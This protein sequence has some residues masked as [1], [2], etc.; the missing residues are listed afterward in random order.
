T[1]TITTNTNNNINIYKIEYK[2]NDR[3]IMMFECLVKKI[4]ISVDGSTYIST[5]NKWN[6]LLLSIVLYYREYLCN[7]SKSISDRRD[8]SNDTNDNNNNNTINNI[9]NITTAKNKNKNI[10]LEKIKYYENKLKMSIKQTLNS[11]MDTRF[12]RVV[13]Y[14]PRDLGGLGMYTIGL[15]GNEYDNN[16]KYNK[17]DRNKDV[18]SIMDYVNSYNTNN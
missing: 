8:N 5:I 16:Y 13:F 3:G 18:I 2:A 12:P 4:I 14:S 9:D 7:N 10:L 15:D 1:N 6:R 11:K 17:K